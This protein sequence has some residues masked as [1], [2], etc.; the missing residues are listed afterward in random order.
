M[1]QM[2]VDTF[3]CFGKY[4]GDQNYVGATKILSADT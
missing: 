2:Q 3:N 1:K 4:V